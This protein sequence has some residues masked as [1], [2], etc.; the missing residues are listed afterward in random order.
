M[1][2]RATERATNPPA[3]A[4]RHRGHREGT[5]GGDTGRGHREHRGLCP[6]GHHQIHLVALAASTDKLILP[7]LTWHPR[8]GINQGVA[9]RAGS[10]LSPGPACPHHPLV[11]DPLGHLSLPPAEAVTPPGGTGTFWFPMGAVFGGVGDVP[12]S[13]APPDVA[14][15]RRRRGSARRICSTNE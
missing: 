11:M 12:P 1:A 15:L 6:W 14:R 9:A 8:N 3:P 4:P 10:H 2:L 7:D 5:Q 13:P